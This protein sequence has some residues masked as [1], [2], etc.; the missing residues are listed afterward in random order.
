MI[1]LKKINVIK[2]IKRKK[3]EST[4]VN[5]TNPPLTI[6]DQNKKKMR[7]SKEEPSKKKKT[8]LNKKILKK[9]TQGNSG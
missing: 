8:N 4:L 9:K 5:L 2:K 3:L 6:C 1:K 7:L